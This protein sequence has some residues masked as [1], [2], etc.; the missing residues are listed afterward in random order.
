MSSTSVTG[1]TLQVSKYRSQAK[2]MMYAQM[3][4]G[5]RGSKG[6]QGATGS[7]GYGGF[8][9]H[10]DNGSPLEHVHCNTC[11]KITIVSRWDKDPQLLKKDWHW[12]N[13][14]HEYYCPE[15]KVDVVAGEPLLDIT[16]PGWRDRLWGNQGWQGIQGPVGSQGMQGFQG[17]ASTG[18]PNVSIGFK[19]Q[20]HQ[21]I[22]VPTLPLYTTPKIQLDA[23]M[24]RKVFFPKIRK[25]IKELASLIP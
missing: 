17:V 11:K 22:A 25:Y 14:T 21:G 15:C 23:F 6:V 2:N 10:P 8:T 24:R 9:P 16:E 12:D 3:Y 18:M 7:Q 5:I 19:G 20:I 4:G 1:M 13:W